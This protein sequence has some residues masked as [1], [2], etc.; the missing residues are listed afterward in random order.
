MTI[1]LYHARSAPWG[2]GIKR[3][4]FNS[5][6][7]VCMELDIKIIAEG[8]EMKD[9]LASLQDLD[10]SLFQ[11]YLFAHPACKLM[12]PILFDMDSISPDRVMSKTP[13]AGL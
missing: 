7:Q 12:P 1:I 10:L 3:V 6:V 11:G 4:I 5:I 2:A 13:Q 8:I 9:D